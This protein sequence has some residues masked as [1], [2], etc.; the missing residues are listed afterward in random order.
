MKLIECSEVT[1]K[2]NSYS[3][4]RAFVEYTNHPMALGKIGVMT[5]GT[6]K[7]NGTFLFVLNFGE[8]FTWFYNSEANRK[9]DIERIQKALYLETTEGKREQMTK[10]FLE[11]LNKTLGLI[12]KD[13][14]Y[15]AQLLIKIKLDMLKNPNDSFDNEKL[16][17]ELDGLINYYDCEAGLEGRGL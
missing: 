5:V 17:D 6:R 11:H 9:K 8:E 4:L 3:Q 14:N 15:K 1:Y 2:V 13:S 10:V 12:N 16:Y 7:K